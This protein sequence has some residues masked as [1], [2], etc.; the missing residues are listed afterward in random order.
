[1]EEEVLLILLPILQEIT[2]LTETQ[3]LRITII[4]EI[5]ITV[6]RDL[7]QIILIRNHSLQE[8][9]PIRILN[10]LE[11]TPI[12]ATNQLLFVLILQ[13]LTLVPLRLV[14]EVMVEEVAAVAEDHHLVVEEDKKIK[15]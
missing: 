7:I 8:V 3:D 6:R 11:I 15:T 10:K 12:E 5:L 13:V 1:M 2:L 9:I 14:A 4:L